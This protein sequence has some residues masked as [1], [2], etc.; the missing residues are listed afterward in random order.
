MS[1]PLDGVRVLDLSRLLPG[2]FCSL[3]LA[4][5]GAEVIKIE[6]PGFGDYIRWIPPLVHGKSYRYLILNRNKKS[7]TLD[8]KSGEGREIFLRLVP[9]SD[10]ILESF[11]PGVAK[12]LN[13]DY[14]QLKVINPRIIY[15]A[16][17][18][19]GQHGPYSNLSGHDID[20]I[21][22][23]GI[24][25]ITGE[26]NGP[27]VIP[28]VQIADIGAGGMLATTSIL[29]A[30][31]S[32][33]K[34][35]K[36]QFVDVSM[37]DGIVSWLSIHAAEYFGEG[38]S[39]ERG[40]M[41]LSGGLAAYNVYET[42]DGKYL[43]LGILEEWFWKNLCI[44]LGRKDLTRVNFMNPVEQPGLFTT[45]RETFRGKT[46]SEWIQELNAADVPCGPVNSIEEVFK[47]AQVLH[48]Q[49]LIEIDHPVAGRIK[50]IGTPI[51][52]SDTP[53]TIRS[54]PPELGEHTVELLSQVLGMS[55]EEIK[56]LQKAK[57][58]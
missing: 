53:L 5:L 10:V 20:Y 38:R 18:G 29:A 37:L 55:R 12:R 33:S 54:A 19:Y 31:L 22:Y 7:L 2:P 35:G 8:L 36:G 9:K 4:D 56:K 16:I 48:R 11:R 30:L 6:E 24:L 13:I 23:G 32:R 49:M 58:V 28:G 14:D 39:P 42:K 26:K 47:D 57:I 44:A 50:Q 25:S 41:M 46:L 52:L 43:T 15:C 51:K 17:S 45:L 3:M 1:L 34:T 40:R 27:P 21:G